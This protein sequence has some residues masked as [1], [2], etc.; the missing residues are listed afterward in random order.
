MRAQPTVAV[1]IP[2]YNH[3]RHLDGALASVFAQTVKPAE[4]I[5]VDDG[6]DDRPEDVAQ[7]Y[8]GVRLIRQ[9]NQG[10][11]AARNTGW[12]A[13]GSDY[14]VFL[15]ADD[16]FRPEAIALNLAQFAEAPGCGFVYG[17]YSEVDEATGAERTF[18]LR[19][20]GADAFMAFLRAN[21]VGMHATV[22]YPRAVLQTVG[23]YDASL[24]AAEDYDLYLRIARDHPVRCRAEVLAE[25]VQHTTNMSRD[26]A[27][28]LR[29][30]LRVL[31]DQRPRARTR[32]EWSAALREGEREWRL[33]YAY[34]WAAAWRAAQSPAERR[35][36]AAQAGAIVRLAPFEFLRELVGGPLRQVVKSARRSAKR[37][38]EG[39]ARA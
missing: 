6:S 14:V 29:S 23:G 17:A 5:V 20:P 31:H 34:R 1:V 30:V 28:M 39:R 33:L 18:D 25:Y 15:D 11:A 21:I 36:L 3:A 19:E 32:P 24:R 2:T 26:S 7:R 12:R 4:I 37:L 16:R 35:R 22:M 27:L 13:S 38:L 10:L 8:A 9:A